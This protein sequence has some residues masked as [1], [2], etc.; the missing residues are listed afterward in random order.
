MTHPLVIRY[1]ITIS[2]A[3]FH[4]NKADTNIN[5]P[6][7]DLEHAKMTLGQVIGTPSG[8]KQYLS[9]V[10]ISNVLLKKEMEWTRILQ[11]FCQ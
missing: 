1:K 5:F 8:H 10:R 6:S 11:F 2:S 4:K 3:F 9:K 7:N